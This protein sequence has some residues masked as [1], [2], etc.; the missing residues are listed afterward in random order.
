[1]DVPTENLAG[2]IMSMH[3][4]YPPLTLPSTSTAQRELRLLCAY[5]DGGVV[6]RRRT[7]PEG[8]QTVGGKGW[9]VI[10]KSRLHVETG[11]SFAC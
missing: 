11:S 7:S 4:Y 5:E 6:L 10:W 2:I 9:D 1:M 8:K 3:L